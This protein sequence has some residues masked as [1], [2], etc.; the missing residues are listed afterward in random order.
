MSYSTGVA[1]GGGDLSLRSRGGGG[2]QSSGGYTISGGGMAS[3]YT[4]QP[5]YQ[6]ASM[7]GQQ[8]MQQTTAASQQMYGSGGGGYPQPAMQSNPM[9]TYNAQLGGAFP[10]QHQQAPQQ[11]MH[12]AAQHHSPAQAFQPQ[13]SRVSGQPPLAAPSFYHQPVAQPQPAF[14]QP[15]QPSYAHGPDVVGYAVD[16]QNT[17]NDNNGY[18]VR[19]TGTSQ[20]ASPPLGGQGDARGAGYGGN[21]R[22][23][24][25]HAYRD[26]EPGGAQSGGFFPASLAV[27][28]DRLRRKQNTDSL[29]NY[30]IFMYALVALS[31]FVM[32]VAWF[33]LGSAAKYVCLVL[34][35][36]IASFIFTLKLTEWIFGKDDG[37]PAM[38]VISEAIREG[39]EGFLRVQYGAIAMIAFIIALVIGIIYLFRESPSKQ[40][41]PQMLAVVTAISY[42]IGAFCS[43]L[44]GYIGVWVSIRVNIR[45]AVAAS[46]Y[47]FKDA[48]LLSFRGGAVSAC[49]SASLCILGVTILY[50]FCHLFFCTWGSLPSKHVPMLLV[51]YGFGGALVAL[52]MQLGGG[53][54]V[55]T[56]TQKARRG[57]SSSTARCAGDSIVACVFAFCVDQSCG[58][59]R[60]HD[61]Q[62]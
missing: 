5:T 53:I 11:P 23:S 15:Q 57:R 10:S 30:I 52:F 26:G 4:Q 28:D 25:A 61:R 3:G 17:P 49:L 35:I 22:V 32:G 20:R 42:I 7:P 27:P 48:L 12:Q 54:Y 40:I 16:E 43:G 62:G 47:S 36:C 50:V 19:R 58:C 2:G 38:R 46:K 34:S 37:N 39:S 33:T 1:G 51:G 56:H 21:S 29:N 24:P 55:R 45:V 31:L 41:S 13:A 59:G 8:P 18:G 44:A 6:Q 9:P 14:P 60:R